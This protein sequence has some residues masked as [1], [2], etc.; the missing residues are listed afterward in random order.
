MTVWYVHRRKDGS[1][2]SAHQEEQPDYATEALDD[3]SNA[4]I[5]AWLLSASLPAE[6]SREQVMRQLAADSKL[7]AAREAIK[8]ADALTQ[9]LWQNGTWRLASM[10]QQPFAGMI[11]ALGIDVP[12]FWAAAARQPS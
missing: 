2:A 10:S 8:T 12:T 4:E 7:D 11:A 5:R 1:I 3:T 9:E 6:L